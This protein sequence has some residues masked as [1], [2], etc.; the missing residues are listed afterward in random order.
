MRMKTAQ[1][2]RV[3]ITIG[4]DLGDTWSHCPRSANFYMLDRWYWAQTMTDEELLE[5]LSAFVHLT[6]IF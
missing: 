2:P 3:G 1:K 5:E 6:T 4:I